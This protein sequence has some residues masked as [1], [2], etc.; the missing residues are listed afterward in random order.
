MTDSRVISY[1]ENTD[2][3]VEVSSMLLENIKEIELV[4]EGGFLNNVYKI[5]GNDDADYEYVIIELPH[6]DENAESF[7]NGLKEAAN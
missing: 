1:I 2:G 7:I 3:N 5:I 6:D 4:E